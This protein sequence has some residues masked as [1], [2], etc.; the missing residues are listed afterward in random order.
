MAVGA[1]DQTLRN[2]VAERLGQSRANH[3]LFVLGIKTDDSIDSFRSV[4]GMKR[5]KH[6]VTRL[7]SFEG[8]LCGF[9]IPHLADENHFGR[10]AQ[11]CTQGGRKVA[12]VMSDFTLVY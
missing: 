10:L 8:D 6:E 3:R 7:R 1:R 2:D 12:R 4:D 9:E 5:G 11:S